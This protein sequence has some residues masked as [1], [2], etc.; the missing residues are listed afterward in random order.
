MKNSQLSIKKKIY[1]KFLEGFSGLF[2]INITWFHGD[3]NLK[4]F[5]D[6]TH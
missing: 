3:L 6:D 1:V 5:S 4:C 2:C